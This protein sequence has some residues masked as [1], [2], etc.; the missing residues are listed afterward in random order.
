MCFIAIWEIAR[1]SQWN[2]KRDTCGLCDIYGGLNVNPRAVS[3]DGAFWVMVLYF[4]IQWK[5]SC[6]TI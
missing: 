4:D 1:E 5:A 2:E 6:S 3:F